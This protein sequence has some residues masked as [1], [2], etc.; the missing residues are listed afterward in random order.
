MF[1]PSAFSSRHI[2]SLIHTAPLIPSPVVW[3]I[4][5]S[6]KQ[7]ICDANNLRLNTSRFE[8]NFG[9]KKKKIKF[10]PKT[11]NGDGFPFCSESK[12]AVRIFATNSKLIMPCSSIRVFEQSNFVDLHECVFV[13]FFFFLLL[14][15][16]NKNYQRKLLDIS[17]SSTRSK[18][19]K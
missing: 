9:R 19:N 4:Q 2:L 11:R 17:L 16:D 3:T 5:I 15:N 7:S 12:S 6:I 13:K 10:N 1:V 8:I 14:Y 18:I